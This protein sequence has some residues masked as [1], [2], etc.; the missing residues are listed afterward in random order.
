MRFIKKSRAKE[1]DYDNI[2]QDM[3]E[4]ETAIS[5]Y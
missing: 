1:K 4:P 3:L 2:E 5:S